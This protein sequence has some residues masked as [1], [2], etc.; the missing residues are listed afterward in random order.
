NLMSHRY[1]AEWGM[2]LD[3]V[4]PQNRMAVNLANLVKVN[5]IR[6][7]DTLVSF[8]EFVDRMK[9]ELGATVS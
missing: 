7:N 6:Y 1:H 3:R 5:I 2:P 4:S 8:G 9:N